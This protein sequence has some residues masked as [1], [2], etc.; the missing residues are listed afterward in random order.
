MRT[1]TKTFECSVKDS[2]DNDARH[3]SLNFR[4]NQ[5]GEFGSTKDDENI[6]IDRGTIKDFAD[7]EKHKKAKAKDGCGKAKV[8][9]STRAYIGKRLPNGNIR[10][11]YNHWDG[12]PEG[13]G[14]ILQTYYTD[15]SKVDA[16]LNEGDVSY[17]GSTLKP[18]PWDNDFEDDGTHTRF[19]KTRGEKDVDAKEASDEDF[20]KALDNVSYAYILGDDGSWS[21]RSTAKERQ[22]WSP[23]KG[24]KK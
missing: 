23:L 16:L 3:K 14:K 24:Y 8:R 11:I 9:D 4:I 21:V 12:Y 6:R 10:Y 5:K 19:Y 15:P 17:L 13:L 1:T 22:P 18:A 2:I 7:I 20:E